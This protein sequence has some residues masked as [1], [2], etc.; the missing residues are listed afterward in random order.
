MIGFLKVEKGRENSY[1]FKKRKIK[2]VFLETN[3]NFFWLEIQSVREE[4]SLKL[5]E[6]Q[7]QREEGNQVMCKKNVHLYKE[8]QN[9]VE[10]SKNLET[11]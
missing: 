1:N 9:I 3:R 11:I 10:N 2:E 4:L 5:S 8:A 7:E 6:S